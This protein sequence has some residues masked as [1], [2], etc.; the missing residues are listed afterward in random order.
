MAD[1]WYIELDSGESIKAD[2]NIIAE[3][4]LYEGRELTEDELTELREAAARF[5]AKERAFRL[6]SSRQMSRK[7]LTDKLTQKGE[8]PE[9]A[10]YAAELMERIGAVNDGEYAHTIVRHYAGKGYGAG[11]IKSELMRRGI[12]KELWEDALSEMP[13]SDD[14][15]DALIA[16]KLRGEAPDRRELKKLTDMLM[17]RGFSWPEIKGALGRYDEMIEEIE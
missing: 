17:R 12:S 6:L 2:L 3:L 11:R 4:S 13:E 14:T 10:E 16:S 1:R 7:E 9:A 15:L 5:G 8:T